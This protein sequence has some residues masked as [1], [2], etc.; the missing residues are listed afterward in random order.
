MALTRAAGI[1]ALLAMTIV[2][3]AFAEIAGPPSYLWRPLFVAGATAFIVGMVAARLLGDAWGPIA[4]ASIVF[5][6]L[7]PT[8]W[9]VLAVPWGALLIGQLLD[10]RARRPAWLAPRAVAS[11][12]G[13]VLIIL[14]GLASVRVVRAAHI[15]PNVA[16]ASAATP[17]SP[18]IYFV[19]L[20]AY[21]R[22]DTLRALGIEIDPFLG[23]LEKLGF[24]VYEDATSEFAWT[25]QT[26]A[27]LFSGT[28]EGVPGR[29]LSTLGQRRVLDAIDSGPLIARASDA[30]YELI[31]I[32]PPL[33]HVTFTAGRHLAHPSINAFEVTLIGRTP[34][35][36]LLG[37]D[38]FVEQLRSRLD[39][40]MERLEQ[41]A[42][43]PGRLVLAHF[44]F[45]HPPFLYGPDGSELGGPAC[46]PRCDLFDTHMEPMPMDRASYVE[47]MTGNISA[48]ND[49][50]VNVLGRMI[51]TDPDAVVV[52]FGDHGT[53][54][55]VHDR[56]EWRRPFLAARTPG[57]PGL[58]GA[59]PDPADSLR[60]I[61]DAYADD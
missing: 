13:V 24:D 22:P 44:M 15:A 52:L 21:G 41:L 37:A 32:D 53:R 4:G 18:N 2:L 14:F 17:A 49:R 3:V 6:M 55:S 29:P 47:G 25:G 12:V 38:L 19:L 57:H 46:W 56:D 33:P 51:T 42:A 10:R 8:E 60:R 7:R 1:P 50:L 54:M 58:L 11:G 9:A 59:A 5:L 23:E 34:L 36:P 43:G 20:D 39:D 48:V 40:D 16:A 61:L 30:G 26:I 31:V 28:S 45:P 27:A 35:G